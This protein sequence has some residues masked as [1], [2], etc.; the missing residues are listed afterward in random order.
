MQIR[1]EKTIFFPNIS[2]FQTAASLNKTES[3]IIISC[4]IFIVDSNGS[5]FQNVSM[6]YIRWGMQAL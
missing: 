2:M 4:V 6:F 5:N 3:S 1:E